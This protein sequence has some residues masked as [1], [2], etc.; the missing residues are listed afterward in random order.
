MNNTR[1]LLALMATQAIYATNGYYDD[2]Y[3]STNNLS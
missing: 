1:K 3:E 2:L